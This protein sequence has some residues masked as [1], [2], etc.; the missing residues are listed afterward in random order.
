MTL[1]VLLVAVAA[2]LAGCSHGAASRGG[3]ASH[4]AGAHLKAAPL[5]LAAAESGLLPWHMPEPLSREVVITGSPGQLIVF[6]GLTAAGTSAGGI[7]SVS[8]AAGTARRIGTLSAPLHDAAAAVSGHQ[9]LIFGGGSPVTVGTVQSF[10]LAGRGAAPHVGSLPEPRSDAQAVTM[11][12]MTYLVGGY[13]GSRPDASVLATTD[14]RSYSTVATLPVP[15]RYP[16]VAAL[17][18]R[19]YAFGGQAVTGPHAGEPVNVI[20]AVDP[21]HRTAAIIGHLPMPLAG[22]TAVTVDGELFVAGGESPAAAQPAPGLGTTQLTGLL[23]TGAGMG[24]TSPPTRTVSAIWAYDSASGRL[25][26]AGRLQVPV[27]HAAVVAAGSTAWIIGGESDGALTSSVQAIRPDRAFGTAGAAGAGSPFFGD[28]LLIADRGNNRLLLLDAAMHVVWKYPSAA[29][30]QDPLGFYFPDDAFFT[31]HGT[32]IISNQEEN[33]TIVKIAYPSGKIIWSYGHPRQPGTATGYLHEPDDAYLLKNGQVTVADAINCRVL[34]INE[35]HT[36]AHQIGTDGVCVHNPP[37]SMGSPNGDT[38]LADGNL[39]VSEINGSWVSEYTL[40]G[41]LVWTVQLPTVGYPSDPQQ[42]GPDTYLL[43]D[44][45]SPGQVVEFDRHGKVLY[46]YDQASGP[47]MLDHPSLA[48]LLPSGVIMANDDHNHRMVAIDPST[49]A[50]V[51]QYGIT[52][53]PGIGPGQLNTPDGFDLVLP[54]GSTP[55]HPA[56]G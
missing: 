32:A 10:P 16:A 52:G 40:S 6:G 14:G 46:R 22:A 39:L 7:Y 31:D 37:A 23:T 42:V 54:D 21:A 8:T 25:L 51:W 38:P 34:V 28:R 27:A 13:D 35:K 20:Q 43:A 3:T 24:G 18:G 15:V 29:G 12:T 55:T 9:A 2:W 5:S 53:K 17:G 56:T 41:R 50:L 36:V 1:V 19:I 4:Q 44:Y 49:G 11:G 33:E 47:G 26:A 30:S 45:S 48:E